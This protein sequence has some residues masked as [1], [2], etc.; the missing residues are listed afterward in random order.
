M[1]KKNKEKCICVYSSSSDLIEDVY[2]KGAKE[3]GRCIA[4]YNYK[5]VYGGGNIGLMAALARAVHENGGEVTGVIPEAL[6]E[7]ELAYENADKLIVTETMRE[8]K[9]IM[10]TS[11]DAFI[12][13]PGGFGTLEEIFEV[14]TL[15][16]L[17]YHNKPI[18]FININNFFGKLF[19][20]FE[21]IY[22]EG[23]ADVKCK[24]LYYISSDAEEAVSYIDSY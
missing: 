17:H 19:D 11:S 2:Y 18:V 15:K 23:F 1:S 8:R 5:L 7:K 6:K 13:L 10:E 9:E 12:A 24:K 4:G 3:L 20:L 22:S 16:Q 14:L 21:H